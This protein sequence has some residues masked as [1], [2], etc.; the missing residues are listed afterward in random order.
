MPDDIV[1]LD[2]EDGFINQYHMDKTF[3]DFWMAVFDAMNQ[4]YASAMWTLYKDGV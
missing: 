4:D 2:T 1:I 3:G